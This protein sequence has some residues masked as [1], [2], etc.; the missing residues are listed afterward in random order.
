MNLLVFVK[1]R[2]NEIKSH[3][4]IVFRYVTSKENPPEIVYCGTNIQTL[5]ENQLWWYGRTMHS[6]T[7]WLLSSKEFDDKTIQ[8]YKSELKKEN[9]KKVQRYKCLICRIRLHTPLAAV[10][11]LALT[12]TDTQQ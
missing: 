6:Y 11:F 7:E 2:V 9:S 4:S 5:R 3:D 10:C 8:D 12:V 1:N